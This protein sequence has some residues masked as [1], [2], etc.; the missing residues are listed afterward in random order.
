MSESDAKRGRWLAPELSPWLGAPRAHLS[1]ARP[2][3][4]SEQP[5]KRER[6]ESPQREA[7][8]EDEGCLYASEHED[9]EQKRSPKAESKQVMFT[10]VAWA[11]KSL[12]ISEAEIQKRRMT[13][14]TDMEWITV[15]AQEVDLCKALRHLQRS[16]G[17]EPV[18]FDMGGA[19][20]TWYETRDATKVGKPFFQLLTDE[21]CKAPEL[22]TNPES[23]Q[24]R[25]AVRM[26]E[27]LIRTGKLCIFTRCSH[28]EHKSTCRTPDWVLQEYSHRC[29]ATIDF[30]EL[31]KEHSDL[32]V[33][34]EQPYTLSNGSQV[35]FDVAVYIGDRLFYVIEVEHTHPN[36][37]KKRK[38]LEEEELVQHAQIYANQVRGFCKDRKWHSKRAPL[39]VLRDYPLAHSKNW[40]CPPCK[41][42][43]DR[44]KARA[45]EL[46]AYEEV[47]KQAR[48]TYEAGKLS[49]YSKP[50]A[51]KYLKGFI[52]LYQPKSEAPKA[53][54][55][56]LNQSAYHQDL[57]PNPECLK[58]MVAAREIEQVKRIIEHTQNG[59]VCVYMYKAP[60]WETNSNPAY[61]DG[62]KMW[63]NARDLTAGLEL[64]KFVPPHPPP[65]LA[66]P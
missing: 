48:E 23:H 27:M 40:F 51:G 44:E 35:K 55:G 39:V 7:H 52:H 36:S 30:G 8:A 33:V 29:T 5:N 9:P 6:E 22:T 3:T 49:T 31:L 41:E 24:H 47:V 65:P 16:S 34:R 26:V 4:M 61:K 38:A 28:L 63:L 43:R 20:H 14:V 10:T 56:R 25:E 50:E 15:E 37:V 32:R 64:P 58:V 57:N 12:L 42:Q 21:D 17:S 54:V 60:Q 1:P 66:R 18:L 53:Y 59:E 19:K 46:A 11:R 62:Y 2:Q 13:V 45:A